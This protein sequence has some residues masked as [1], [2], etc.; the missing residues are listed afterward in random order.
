M[1]NVIV[2][3]GTGFIGQN[4]YRN[5]DDPYLPYVVSRSSEKA[6]SLFGKDVK[7]IEWDARN[8]DPDKFPEKVYA[9]VNLAGENLAKPWTAKQ[10][11]KIR[12]S[13]I[14]S[15]KAVAQLVNKLDPKPEVVIQG[16]AVGLYGNGGEHILTEKSD[17]GEG[18]LADVVYEWEQSLDAID[19]NMTRKIFIRSGIVLGEENGIIGKIK[20][21]FKFFLGGPLGNGKQWMS[22]IHIEDEVRAI[23]HLLDSDETEGAYNLVSPEPVRHKKLTKALGRAMHRP[24]WFRVPAFLLK[25]LMGDM[26][27]EMLLVSQRIKPAH[28]LEEGF[29]FKY[30][31]IEKA[32][33]DLI[34]K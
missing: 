23:K 24:S 7:V 1:K 29:E 12:Q 3:G 28:L 30:G 5:L 15:T 33:K 10:K 32:M 34:N 14:K 26:A 8:I 16:S 19:N 21:P 18:F 27:D 13:R 2:I 17:R 6:R 31:N 25:L 20:L 9:V 11:K 22:W 4:I